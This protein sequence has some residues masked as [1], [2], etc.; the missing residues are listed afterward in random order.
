MANDFKS[1]VGYLIPAAGIIGFFTALF[2]EEPLVSIIIAIGGILIW[3]LYM[4][5]MESHIPQQMGNMII[6]FG[7]ML[8]LGIFIGFGVEQHLHG[9][10]VLQIEGLVFSLVILFFSVLTGL[11]FRNQQNAPLYSEKNGSSGLSDKDRN[12]VLDAINNTKNSIPSE[13]NQDPKVI[14]VKQ[15]IPAGD[16]KNNLEKLSPAQNPQDPYMA[17]NNPYFSYP[18]DYYY[19]DDDDDEYEDDW[20]EYEDDEY[21]D[22]K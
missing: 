1:G 14:V 7:V 19:D 11:N 12:L 20:D 16:E 3:F 22:E 8:S 17:S 13:V 6:L 18:P 2:L 21:E 15:E 4:L 10:Y 9:G 5:V